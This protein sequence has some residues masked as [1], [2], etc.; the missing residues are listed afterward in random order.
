MKTTYAARYRRAIL[1]SLLCAAAIMLAG[2][3]RTITGSGPMKTEEYTPSPF[4]A[5]SQELPAKVTLEEGEA[6]AVRIHTYENLFEHIEVLVDG[7]RLRIRS[8]KNLRAD[9]SIA[10]RVIAPRMESVSIVGSATVGGTATLRGETVAARI[11]GSGRI[12]LPVEATEADIAISGSGHIH[13]TG[14]ADSVRARISGSGNIRTGEIEARDA[15]ADIS[16]S[17][18]IEV[19]ASQSLRARIS[20]SGR[21]IYGGDA[22]PDVAVSGSGS[23]RPANRE[24][25]E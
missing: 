12:E 23:V 8:D 19:Y 25:V 7:D 21:I 3:S 14:A 18:S 6:H 1:L 11:S 20:G 24:A 22:V 10:V 4:T 15:V 9:P 2:C 5:L 13:L 16:G 17:G